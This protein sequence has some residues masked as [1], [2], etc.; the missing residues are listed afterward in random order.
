M[1]SADGMR[2]PGWNHSRPGNSEPR[3]G[4]TSRSRSFFAALWYGL[5]VQRRFLIVLLSL[6]AMLLSNA[7]LAGYACPGSDKAV[8]V[9][10]MVEAGTPCADTMSRAMDDEQPGLC[11]AH[12][13]S[14]SQSADTFH[15][16]V[17]AA[18]MD[19]GP[20]LTV[21][22]ALLPAERPAPH[23][24]LLGRKTGPPLAISF[25]CFRT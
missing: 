14:S 15:T 8:E 22:P 11:H 23:P 13:Q 5:V 24:L 2:P 3:L 12:C 21:A 10:Q 20:V 9:D 4:Y 17:F 6:H 1:P 18:L 16:P 19:M 7:A 25:C